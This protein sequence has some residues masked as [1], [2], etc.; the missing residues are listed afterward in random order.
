M[1]KDW[2]INILKK[3]LGESCTIGMKML[4]KMYFLVVGDGTYCA[5]PHSELKNTHR[6]EFDSHLT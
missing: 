3:L 5:E 2:N 1:Y 4:R 6:Y